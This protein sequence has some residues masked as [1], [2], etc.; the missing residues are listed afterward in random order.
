MTT[1][2]KKKNYMVRGAIALLVYFILPYFEAL[3]FQ[4]LGIDLQ[5]VPM[6]SKSIYMAAY[7]TV[8]LCIIIFLFQDL[9]KEKWCDMKKNHQIYFQKYFKFWFL[10]LGLMMLSNLIILII[11]RNTDGAANQQAIINLFDQA[12][13]YTFL[14]AVVFAPIV[15]ELVFRQAIRSILPK[16]NILFIIVSGIVFGGLHVVGNITDFTQLL[17]IIPYSIPGLI[18]AYV[19]TKSDNIFTTMGLHFVHNGVL[20]ALQILILLFS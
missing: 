3:P 18:F 10:L 6:I 13:I 7:E 16:W 19:L 8:I 14:S 1:I 20:M 11:T 9:L 17:Y 15:E 5:Y 12:P 2:K 4:I